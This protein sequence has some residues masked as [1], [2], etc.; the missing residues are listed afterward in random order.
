[1]LPHTSTVICS[2]KVKYHVIYLTNS[3]HF[4]KNKSTNLNQLIPASGI[5][6]KYKLHEDRK[7]MPR[8][9]RQK[10]YATEQI[11][12]M[13][14]KKEYATTESKMQP[15]KEVCHK[16]K[17]LRQAQF[18]VTAFGFPILVRQNT[19]N[20]LLQYSCRDVIEIENQKE[21]QL[22]KEL[23][24]L[25]TTEKRYVFKGTNHCTLYHCPQ[26][27][28][29]TMIFLTNLVHTVHV[30]LMLVSCAIKE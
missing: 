19:Y 27:K 16:I 29:T 13:P 7:N 21:K 12:T 8:D 17:K 22:S 24:M 5:S 14:H 25:K 1:M 30:L 6:L 4:A 11:Q 23:P 3:L 10:E 28:N 2:S 18:A 15:P 20:I 26:M 9:Q